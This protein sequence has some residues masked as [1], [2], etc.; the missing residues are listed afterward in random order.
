VTHVLL[1]VGWLLRRA[2]AVVVIG[3]ALAAKAGG[4]GYRRIAAWLRRP[5][6]TV[7]GWLRRFGGRVEAVRRLFTVLLRAMAPDPVMPASAGGA[8]ADALA[9]LDA[10]VSAVVDRFGVLEA[11][12]WGWVSA[13]SGGRLLAP[14]WPTG[15][16]QHEL[17]L[18][19]RCSGR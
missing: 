16:D 11:P 1:P 12:P 7:R 3:A 13:V 15:V 19:R 4:A 17:T 6:E 9:V 8:W 5:A 10:A 14:G 18:T 2:D